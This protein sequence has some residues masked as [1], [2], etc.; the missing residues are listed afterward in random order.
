MW[1]F[2]QSNGLG[3]EAVHES[4]GVRF[5]APVR[6]AVWKQRE[7]SMALVV[8]PFTPPD[9]EVL[10]VRELGPSDA[11]PSVASCDQGWGSCHTK[12]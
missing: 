5:D 12:Q 9:I 10:G 11:P 6:L 2:Y 4:V 8:V 7:Q 3:M 1:P